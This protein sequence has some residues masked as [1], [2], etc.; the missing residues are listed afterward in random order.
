MTTKKKKPA[1]TLSKMQFAELCELVSMGA[2]AKLEQMYADV[3]DYG[4]Q[5][6]EEF[7]ELV[8]M[9]QD[10]HTWTDQLLHM[11]AKKFGFKEP[12]FP[13]DVQ[14]EGYVDSPKKTTPLNAL[15]LPTAVKP[16]A[17]LVEVPKPELVIRKVASL[18]TPKPPVGVSKVT[19]RS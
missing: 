7:D 15:R 18:A 19:R 14:V 5:Q 17:P 4:Y 16:P 12:L 11:L 6:E 1:V 13:E 9:E 8:W 2:E 3:M 10:L